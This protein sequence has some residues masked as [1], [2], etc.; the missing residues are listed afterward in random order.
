M[1]RKFLLL[2]VFFILF[3]NFAYA[4]E[5][6][7][8]EEIN[9]EKSLIA[10]PDFWVGFGFNTAFY[11]TSGLSV[12]FNLAVGYGSGS[13]IGFMA[14]YF[15]NDS[16]SSILEFDLLLRFYLLGKNAFLGPFLQAVGGASLANYS[17]S[18]NIPSNTGV[19]NAGLGFG[20]RLIDVN[21][22]YWEPSIRVGYP[23]Y[24]CIVLSIGIR[25]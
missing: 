23:Y 14:S 25:T 12:G 19:F 3:T 11:N 5:E 2:A 20:W 8:T 7:L 1:L 22:Y 10:R 15:L 9:T 24:C 6:N 16:D 18:M 4:Q 13:S 17:V 21:K